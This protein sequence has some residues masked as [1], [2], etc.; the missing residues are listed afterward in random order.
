ME[1]SILAADNP[2]ARARLE[3]GLLQAD[4]AARLHITERTISRY[5]SGD[6]VPRQLVATALAAAVDYLRNRPADLPPTNPLLDAADQLRADLAA[7]R[8]RARGGSDD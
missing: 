8:V 4:L 6:F 5:E 2:L 1:T 3:A 7:W